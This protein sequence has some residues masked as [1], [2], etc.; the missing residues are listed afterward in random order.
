MPP[1]SADLRT[2]DP[3][4]ASR[5]VFSPFS[6]LGVSQALLDIPPHNWSNGDQHRKTTD[7][8]LARGGSSL[9][10]S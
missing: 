4:L 3:R 5:S 2:R 6:F 10:L 8:R 7:P 9:I 1:P